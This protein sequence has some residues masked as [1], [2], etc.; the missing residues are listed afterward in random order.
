M[1]LI[2]SGLL[3]MDPRGRLARQL[4]SIETF[5]SYCTRP[6][7]LKGNVHVSHLGGLVNLI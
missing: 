6:V 4:S 2:D 7:V 1:T 5:K 3:G